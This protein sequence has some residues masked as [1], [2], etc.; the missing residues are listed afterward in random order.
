MENHTE[1]NPVSQKKEHKITVHNSSPYRL[2][3]IFMQTSRY[4][5]FCRAHGSDQENIVNFEQG[6][7]HSQIFSELGILVVNSSGNVQCH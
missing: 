2:A 5:A 1:S 6:H 4:T 7:F 3:V